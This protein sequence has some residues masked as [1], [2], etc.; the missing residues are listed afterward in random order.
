MS[1]KFD[2]EGT[3][4]TLLVFVFANSTSG[5][6]SVQNRLDTIMDSAMADNDAQ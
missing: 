1:L 5:A 4:V 2:E 6:E 3:A